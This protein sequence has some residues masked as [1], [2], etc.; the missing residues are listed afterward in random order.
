MKDVGFL[1]SSF[2]F[3]QKQKIISQKKKK[4]TYRERP[5]ERLVTDREKD[6]K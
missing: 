4:L 1:F 6:K 5:R 3:E 2:N